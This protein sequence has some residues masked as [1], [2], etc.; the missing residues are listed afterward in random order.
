[1]LHIFQCESLRKTI[2]LPDNIMFCREQPIRDF[3][4]HKQK[5]QQLNWK[6]LMLYNK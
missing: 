2:I 6:S 4:I 3:L 1:M 5:A